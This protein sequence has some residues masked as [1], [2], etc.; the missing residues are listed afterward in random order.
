MVR[1]GQGTYPL[2]PLNLESIGMKKPFKDLFLNLEQ[3]QPA[4]VTGN[5]Y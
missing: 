4:N 2:K 1:M 3:A 5:H